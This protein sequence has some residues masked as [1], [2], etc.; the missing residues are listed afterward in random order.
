MQWTEVTIQTTTEGSD[1]M[2]EVLFAQGISGVSIEDPADISLYQRPSDEWD[3]IDES[4]FSNQGATVLV[5]GYLPP[6]QDDKLDT[7]RAEAKRIACLSDGNIDFGSGEVT[8]RLVRDEDWSE[9]WK[10]YYKPFVV[11][12]TL[13]V[14]PCWETFEEPGRTVVKLEPGAA[15]GTGQHETTFMCLSLAEKRD[16]SGLKVLDI[17]CGT[18]ILGI[19]SV[20]MGAQTATLIDRDPV[21]VS[22]STNNAQLNGC[23]EKT[24][25]CQ[26]NLADQVQ[27]TYDVVFANIVADVIIALLPELP[28]VLSKD[29]VI[30]A[31]GIIKEREQDV[32]E[33][34]KRHNFITEERMQQ[35]EWIALC[36]R[37]Q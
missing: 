32:A 2:A 8:T 22:A 12:D 23:T 16:L 5:K 10:Q 36:M 30:I 3:Y 35:G 14:T 19:A 18:G 11:G 17:G 24:V 37:M 28:C 4:I 15:F 27:G 25:I 13:A 1:A 29:G 26:G 21:A 31:S 6:Q 33:A 34:A 7:I 20:C 9:N